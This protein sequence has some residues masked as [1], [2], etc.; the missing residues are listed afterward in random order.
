[1]SDYDDEF[2]SDE[3]GLGFIPFEDVF[4]KIFKTRERIV[5]VLKELKFPHTRQLSSYSDELL[6]DKLY[7]QA[8]HWKDVDESL[9]RFSVLDVILSAAYRSFTPTVKREVF[10]GVQKE[11]ELLPI[12]ANDYVKE[13]Y[14]K[15][16]TEVPMGKS[17]A[18]LLA[19]KKGLLGRKMV[20]VE[21][22]ARGEEVKRLYDQVTDYRRYV[23]KVVVAITPECAIEYTLKYSEGADPDILKDK[24]DKLD[25]E[26]MM[27]DATSG[28]E[29]RII[30]ADEIEDDLDEQYEEDL[31]DI[32]WD[33]AVNGELNRLDIDSE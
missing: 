32:L 22:K 29:P 3:W 21:L 7:R 24:L 9:S 4:P 31:Y 28:E 6:K 20:A 19:I 30:N 2:F 10:G 11:S 15:L 1:M 18:D 23:D 5:G 26:L 33:K 25:V 14:K 8:E 17:I 12:V 16:F 13:G 27:V